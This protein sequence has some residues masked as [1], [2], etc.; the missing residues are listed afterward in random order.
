MC[1]LRADADSFW[2]PC[3]LCPVQ[4][5][6]DEL[7]EDYFQQRHLRLRQQLQHLATQAALSSTVRPQEQQ[8]QQQSDLW[9]DCCSIL[10]QQEQLRGMLEGWAAERAKL[11]QLPQGWPLQAQEVQELAA[12]WELDIRQHCGTGKL[13]TGSTIMHVMHLLLG[14]RSANSH[15]LA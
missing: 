7:D 3:W 2:V 9:E 5:L 4:V 10:L 6:S 14:A 13:C 1:T 12:S 8:Q 11:L 15:R